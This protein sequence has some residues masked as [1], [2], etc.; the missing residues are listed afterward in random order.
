[1]S[2]RFDPSAELEPV[3]HSGHA[4]AVLQVYAQQHEVV[5]LEQPGTSNHR[6]AQ[7]QRSRS[8]SVSKHGRKHDGS[9]QRPL[10]VGRRP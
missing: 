4:R 7:R 2:T 10:E 1:M 9:L 5:V 3:H 8:G 6:Q